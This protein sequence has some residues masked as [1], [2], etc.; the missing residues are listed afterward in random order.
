M[1]FVREMVLRIV[2]AIGAMLLIATGITL[3]RDVNADWG[4]FVGA[5]VGVALGAAMFAVV[6]RR[7]R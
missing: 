3:G 1:L 4:A 5:V 6:L 2:L 7:R